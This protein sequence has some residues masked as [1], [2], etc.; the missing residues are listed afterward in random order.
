[1]QPFYVNFFRDKHYIVKEPSHKMKKVFAAFDEEGVY[2]YQAFKPKIVQVAVE[3]GTF[4][5]GFGLDRIS[6]IK[7][8]LAWTLQRSK[9]ATKHRME[10]IAQIKIKHESW[11]EILNQSVE[12]QFVGTYWKDENTWQIAMNKSDVIHQWDPERDLYGRKLEQAAI[13]VGIRGEVI[14]QYVNDF[15]IN[16]EDVTALANSIGVLVKNRKGKLPQ[17]PEEKEYPLPLELK[18]RLGYTN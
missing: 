10:A 13:Q 8:S 1:M 7:P 4:G 11:L 17:V 2:V 12:T 16:V 14:K 3:L 9:Y 6:W 15:I 18:L 5:K